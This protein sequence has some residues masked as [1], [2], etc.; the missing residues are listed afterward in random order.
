MTKAR[1]KSSTAKKKAPKKTTAKA[2]NR[3]VTASK[4]KAAKKTPAKKTPAKK[5]TTRKAA[6]RKAASKKTTGRKTTVAKKSTAS[7]TTTKRAKAP[8]EKKTAVQADA[9]KPQAEKTSKSRGKSKMLQ[10][11]FLID[12]ASAIR[13]A[14]L[15]AVQGV[16]G[17]EAVGQA[18]NGDAILELDRLAERALLSFLK[19][20]KLPVAYYSE[21]E[22][23]AT[24]SSAQPENLLVVNPVDGVHAAKSGFENCVV[25]VASTRVIERPHMGDVDSACVMEILGDRTF[26]AARGKGARLY[27]GDHI[28]R[29]RLSKNTNLEAVSWAMTVPARP[30]ELIFPTAAKLIDLTSLKGGFFSCNSASYSL[31]RLLTNQLDAC[32]DFANR[33]LRDIPEH[34][35]DHFINAGRGSVT[36]VAPYDMAAA[37]LI[38][39]EAGCVVTDAYGEGF[40]DVLLLDSGESNHRSIVAASNAGL[41]EKL[42]RFFGTRIKQFELLL[43]RRAQKKG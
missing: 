38:A 2:K 29:P 33:F 1:A 36:G 28:R 23:Y 31:T 3:S 27:V 10:R 7:K 17:R 16:K 15:P 14:V 9:R 13:N 8:A 32:V 25:S 24:F 12:L 41:H 35:R 34:V 26:Y 11:D 43:K 18:A 21:N 39:Q 40:D 42:M 5:K 22:G 30:A 6:A 19:Q 37:L 20:A 4:K